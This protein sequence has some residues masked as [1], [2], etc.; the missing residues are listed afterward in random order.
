MKHLIKVLLLVMT[1]FLPSVAHGRED[2][3]AGILEKCLLREMNSPDSIE[4]NLALLEKAR[5]GKEGV[6]KALYTACLAQLYSMRAYSDATGEWR[7]RSKELFIEALSNPKLLY[8]AKTKDYL[9]IVMRGKDEKIWGSNMLY[10]VWY[11]ANQW[12]NDSI[13]SEEALLELNLL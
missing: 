12:A 5:E 4:Y 7:K 9:P 10:V 11:A 8:D 2:E 6:Q 3:L 1:M 13:M